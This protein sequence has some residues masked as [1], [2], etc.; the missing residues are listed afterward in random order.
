MRQSTKA[1]RTGSKIHVAD[2][3]HST[4]ALGH[5]HSPFSATLADREI[6][7]CNTLNKHVITYPFDSS[8]MFLIK[9]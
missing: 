5:A 4:S 7:N 9:N 8:Y 2:A 1:I 3:K 6:N